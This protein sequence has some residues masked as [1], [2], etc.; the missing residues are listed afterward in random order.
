M[1][2]TQL[3]KLHQLENEIAVL[4]QKL[5]VSA[6]G[7]IIFQTPRSTWSEADVVV[8]ADGSGGATLLIVEGNYPSDYL[9][10]KTQFF[11]TEEAACEEAERMTG[12]I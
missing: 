2:R 8:E 3:K 1:K 5:G 7:E 12:P 4:K 11:P 6:R 9:T 10:H